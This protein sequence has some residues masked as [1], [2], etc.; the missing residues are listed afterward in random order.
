[1]NNT[2]DVIVVGA[3]PA[4]LMAAG[5]SALQGIRTLLVEKMESPGIKLLL[6]GKGRCNLTNTAD[7]DETLDHFNK[8]GRF[9]KNVYYRF[10]NQDLLD[11]I[12]GLGIQ[13]ITERGGRI[14][15]SSGKSREILNTLLQ[16][17]ERSG[18]ELITKTSATGLLIEKG[19]IKG[20]TTNTGTYHAPKIVL[21]TGGKAYPGT[22][23]TGDGYA[24]ARLAGHTIQPLYP[25]L[26]PL[27]TI[28]KTARQLQGLTLKN[29]TLSAWSNDDFLGELFGE[30]LFTHFG[31]SGPVVLSLS[32]I[33]VPYLE[34]GKP[35]DVR[36]DLKPALDHKT[37]DD[38]LLRDITKLGKKQFSS[39]LEGLLP[40]KLIL[41]CLEHTGIGRDVKNSQLTSSDRHSLISWLKE[42]FRFSISGHKGFEQAIITAGG[43]DTSEIDPRTMES[44]IV[45][46]LYFAGE[47]INIDADTGGFNLQ[48]AF[49]TGWAAGR[50][51]GKIEED[52]NNKK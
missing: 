10:F 41:L 23:S 15:P 2:Y 25:S 48:A 39:L 37:L 42:D 6:T 16:W 44:K 51:A 8:Q 28:G 30:L 4:G 50:A 7:I 14:F 34:E 13:T 19:Q 5:Q 49:S 21:A 40:K 3:G 29:I 11:F 36:I 45:R 33:I 26:V 47:I 1:L 43:I 46:G 9:L 24:L 18:V 22:G 32:K 31:I 12:N 20:L 27:I 17:T 52:Q 38:R 35:V